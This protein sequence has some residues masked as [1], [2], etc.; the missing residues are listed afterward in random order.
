MSEE[1]VI[2][3]RFPGLYK[4]VRLFFSDVLGIV[5]KKLGE[6]A[7]WPKD[8]FPEIEFTATGGANTRWV[9]KPDVGGF[10]ANLWPEAAKLS[11]YK[12]ALSQ[13]KT[14][15]EERKAIGHIWGD[16]SAAYL[17]PLVQRYLHQLE[18][19]FDQ[20]RFQGIYDDLEIYLDREFAKARVFLHLQL[21]TGD[22]GGQALELDD[23]H[24]IIRLDEDTARHIWSRGA[25]AEVPGLSRF[26]GPRIIPLPEQF[27]L[28]GT[29]EFPKDDA[30][31]LS[32]LLNSEATRSGSAV[33]LVQSG[34]GP[35]K[36]IGYDFIGF[37][38]E[39]GRLGFR[40]EYSRGRFSYAMNASV[41]ERMKRLWGRCIRNI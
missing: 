36:L 11:S 7:A 2:A 34:S 35:I 23:R 14:L 30:G 24:S 21:L 39:T 33:R 20:S 5:R 15:Q 37:F 41:A 6:P 28:V 17:A 9:E 32:L 31:Q 25:M 10:I 3:V 12:D 26:W 27:V 16:L 40:E 38:P 8:F 29:L 13:L 18:T 1:K 19:A 4:S 22:I